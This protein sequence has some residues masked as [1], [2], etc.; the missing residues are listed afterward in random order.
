MFVQVDLLIPSF[1]GYRLEVQLYVRASRDTWIF[2]GLRS[3]AKV[4]TI[5]MRRYD[6]CITK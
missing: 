3:I 1:C 5:S 2:H 6:Q 4:I